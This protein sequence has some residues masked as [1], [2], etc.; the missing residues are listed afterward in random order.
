[1]QNSFD[2]IQNITT[3]ELAA[4]TVTLRSDG[5]MN[6]DL[7]P[8]DEFTGKDAWEILGAVKEIGSGKKFPNL[9]TTSKGY[10][11]ISSEARA[12]SASEPGNIYTLA[13][14]IVVNS[15]AFKLIANFYI[16]FNKPVR[17]TRLFTSEKEAVEW[18]KTFLPHSR[19]NK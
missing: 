2:E 18:L 11:A 7:K 17:P 5:I 9:I 1:M 10:V 8:V 3:I 15:T 13:D 12:L 6:F 16:S 4:C 14:A 19:P